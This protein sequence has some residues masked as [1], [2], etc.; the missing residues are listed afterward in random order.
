MNRILVIEDVV[1]DVR[2]AGDVL[3][4]LGL[5]DIRVFR[6]IPS[7][8]RELNVALEAGDALPETVILDLNFNFESGFEILRLWHS[9]P[10]FRDA[11]TIIVWTAMGDTEHEICRAFGVKTVVPKWEGTPALERALRSTMQLS[12]VPPH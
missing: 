3:A 9:T 10:K 8:L 4:S 5:N 7:A 6:D 12:E 2:R 11:T 1:S